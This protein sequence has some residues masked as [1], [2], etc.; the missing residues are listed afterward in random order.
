MSR[1]KIVLPGLLALMVVGSVASATALAAPDGPWFR[2]PVGGVQVKWPMNEHKE[3]EGENQGSFTFTFKVLNLPVTIKCATVAT[4]GLVWNGAHQGHGESEVAFVNCVTTQL[5]AGSEVNLS[6]IKILSE[7]QFK[8]AGKQSELNEQPPNQQKIFDVFAPKEAPKQV[9]LKPKGE[10]VARAVLLTFTFPAAC[11]VGTEPFPVEA[12]GTVAT[13]ENQRQ[14]KQPV[15]WFA[16][17]ETWPQNQDAP[18][19]TLQWKVPNT[20]EFHHQGVQT[21]AQLLF[22]GSPATLEGI[23]HIKRAGVGA[24]EEFGV[25]KE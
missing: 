19:G 4:A 3:I 21:K 5:C 2:H 13:F 25:F 1:M 11:G 20:T 6:T 9:E 17:A 24:P 7:L 12:A 18:E 16:G 8:Y 23:L 10:K 22:A 15:I 14:E